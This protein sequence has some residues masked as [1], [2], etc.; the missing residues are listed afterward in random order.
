MKLGV[1]IGWQDKSKSTKYIVVLKIEICVILL[2]SG[3]LWKG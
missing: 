3:H 2:E 1:T